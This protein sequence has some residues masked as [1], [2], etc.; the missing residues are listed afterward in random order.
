M[1]RF[2]LTRSLPLALFSL[3]ALPASSRADLIVIPNAYAGVEGENGL[4][5]PL[6]SNGRTLQTAIA[7]S[8]L[9]ALLPG[10]QITGLTYRL[11]AEHVG[12][13][14]AADLTWAQYNIQLSTSNFPPGSLDPEFSFN[15]GADVV[16]VRSGPLTIPAG[17][18][19]DTA[20]VPNAFGPMILFS[21]PYT[22]TGGD[23]L[24]T[25]RHTGNSLAAEHMDAV[26]DTALISTLAAFSF[27]G[28]FHESILFNP[29]SPVY[30]LQF[31]PVAVPEP[32]T[33][34]LLSV[35]VLSGYAR[36]RRKRAA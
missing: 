36:L 10:S 30:Q 20:G 1:L 22:Y 29:V 21:T 2:V 19:Q 15:I 14:P 32:A 28:S 25:I 4:L 5:G 8:E 11:S 16:A 17:S 24:I 9:T 27:A 33:F 35:G 18:L 7:A 34:T 23:L 3:L 12:S 13:W 31:E 26:N 6:A